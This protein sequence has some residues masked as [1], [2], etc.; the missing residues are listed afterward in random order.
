MKSQDQ[1]P[2]VSVIVPAYN[3]EATLAETLASIVAQS[4]SKLEIVIVDDG[5]TDRTTVI[6]TAFTQADP[7]ARLLSIANGG[8]AI[9][10]NTGIAAS[11]GAFVAPIDADDLW[12]PDYLEKLVRRMLEAPVPPAFAYA[13]CR[14]LDP[15]SNVIG[16]GLNAMAE[17]KLIYRMLYCNLVGNGSGMVIAREAIDAVGGYDP[18]LHAAGAQGYEDYLLQLMLASQG[19][20]CA[21]GEFLVGYRQS[22]E[23]MSCDVG[24]MAASARL[25]RRLHRAAV[26]G[27]DAP[28]WLRRWIKAHGLLLA[29]NAAAAGGRTGH[30]IRLL[31]EATLIDPLAAGVAIVGRTRS[32]A[33][34]RRHPAAR[35]VNFFDIDPARPDGNMK[36]GD[37][38]SPGL[39]AKLQL[40]RLERIAAL[41]RYR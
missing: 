23:A 13:A 27:I 10:R 33:R 12:H 7:R 2:L 17:G 14:L 19:P 28:R 1:Q 36:L 31:A 38:A 26:P 22:A 16:S 39:F 40:Q 32:L 29:A 18:R 34:R 9:A 3:A 37:E 41:D 4:Y 35:S 8:V 21:A 15:A 5:S 20:A 25:A 24:R 6:A 11:S 30:A